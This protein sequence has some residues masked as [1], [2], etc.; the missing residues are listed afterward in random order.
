MDDAPTVARE[1][2][3]NQKAISSDM[4]FERNSYDP[5][6]VNAAQ[7]R[8]QSFQGA[9]AI[10]SNQYFGRDEDE[11]LEMARQASLGD[12]SLAGLEVAARDAIQRVLAN[13]DVQ[14]VGDSIR[15]GALKVTISLICSTGIAD[16]R[17][18]FGLLGTDVD[19]RT[20]RG[21]DIYSITVGYFLS[22]YQ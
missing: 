14:N 6:T 11:E 2:F 8:L 5:S 4:Y 22:T 7:S 1:K 18:A 13:P 20:M 16:D 12:G 17:V 21:F 19:G 3:G 9:S 15:A 10:S